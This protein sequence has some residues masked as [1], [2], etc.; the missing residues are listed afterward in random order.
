MDGVFII[1]KPSGM[2]SF[3]V[4]RR[5]RQALGTPK[6]GHTG[7]LDPMA[8]GVLPVCVG[9]ATK[10]AGFILEGD[11]TYDAVVRLGVETDT[12]DAEGRVLAEKPVPTF[13]RAQLENVLAQFRGSFDQLPPMFSAIKVAGKRL[14]ESARAGEEVE[15]KPRHVTVHALVLRDFSAN[16]VTLSVTASKGFYVRSLAH[17][18]GVALGCGAHLR[19]LRRT[20]SGK[21]GLERAIPLTQ[22]EEAARTDGGRRMLLQRMLT[23]AAGLSGLPTLQLTASE[24]DRVRHGVPL[25]KAAPPGRPNSPIALLDPD[26]ALVAVS[27]IDKG[28]LAYRRV[29]LPPKESV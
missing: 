14:Y 3:D 29:L 8:T 19:M 6:A 10:I 25:E 7:T 20:H 13:D 5:V 2:T 15:R 17:D 28:R 11:K 9:E 27:D 18:I 23:P 26:G 1:D 4:V 24:V 12:L 16:E 21:F 22:F